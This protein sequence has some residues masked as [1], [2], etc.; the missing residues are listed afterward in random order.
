L[1]VL[2]GGNTLLSGEGCVALR[3]GNFECCSQTVDVG[4]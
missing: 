4:W 2:L 3:D 1:L